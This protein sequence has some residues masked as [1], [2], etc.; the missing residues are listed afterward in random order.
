MQRKLI[1][2]NLRKYWTDINQPIG[3]MPISQDKAT[4]FCYSKNL[5]ILI[6]INAFELV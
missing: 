6:Y 4:F 2:K 1:S 3:I 5:F